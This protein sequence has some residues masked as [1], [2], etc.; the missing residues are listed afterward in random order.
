MLPVGQHDVLMHK[1]TMMSK[2]SSRQGL[3]PS[4]E[5]RTLL[6]N[7]LLQLSQKDCEWQW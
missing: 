4:P 2:A 3:R 1:F 5:A 6:E 7:L